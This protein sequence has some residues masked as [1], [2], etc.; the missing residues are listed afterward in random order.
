MQLIDFATPEEVKKLEQRRTVAC[1]LNAGYTYAEIARD[2]HVSTQTISKVS[3]IMRAL[4][5]DNKQ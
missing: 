2:F 1:A 4:R 5:A 3:R